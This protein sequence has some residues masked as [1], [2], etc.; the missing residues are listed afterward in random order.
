MDLKI[1]KKIYSLAYGI[2]FLVISISGKIFISLRPPSERALSWGG[3]A[4]LE[5]LNLAG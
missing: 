1:Y 2:L 3:Q 4:I 5:V